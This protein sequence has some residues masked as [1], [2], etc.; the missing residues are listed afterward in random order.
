[1]VNLQLKKCYENAALLAKINNH[2]C[3]LEAVLF[4]QR[5]QV[6]RLSSKRGKLKPW[7]MTD[8]ISFPGR[9]SASSEHACR[10]VHSK[11]GPDSCSTQQSA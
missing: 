11:W 10:L 3:P 6:H 4:K 9:Q 1:M 7:D 5:K 8:V 2:C